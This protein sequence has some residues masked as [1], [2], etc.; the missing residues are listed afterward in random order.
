MENLP[1]G[2]PRA[3]QTSI[4]L[5]Q[6]LGVNAIAEVPNKGHHDRVCKGRSRANRTR[7]RHIIDLLH[8]PYLEERAGLK[9]SKQI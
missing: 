9:V 5:G 6:V 4:L 8:P 2:Q 7:S 1:S 3:T